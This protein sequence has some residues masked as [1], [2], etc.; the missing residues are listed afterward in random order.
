MSEEMLVRHCSPTLAALKTANLVNCKFENKEEL[1]INIAKLNKT[2]NSKGVYIRLLKLNKNNALVYVFRPCKLERD[3][4]SIEARDI[5]RGAGYKCRDI[6]NSINHL[7]YRIE[8]CSEF[9]HEIGLFL[10]YPLEDIKGFIENK[11]K[12]C[13]C[14]GCWKVYC[15]EQSAIK[16]FKKYKK[17]TDVY[18]RKL[19]E[20]RSINQLTINVL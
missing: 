18:C 9:P 15:N 3:L 17:C 13:L 8:S 20:G 11:G 16:I 7:A 1:I 5:L 19:K 6:S 2:L 14:T 12:N 4:S 10:G